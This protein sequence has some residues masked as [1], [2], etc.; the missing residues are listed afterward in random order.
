MAFHPQPLFFL[1]VGLVAGTLVPLS[2]AR[3][4]LALTLALALAGFLCAVAIARPRAVPLNAL[5]IAAAAAGAALSAEAQMGYERRALPREISDVSGAVILEGRLASD[6]RVVDNEM[7][8]EVDATQI[9]ANGVAHAYA[10]R[11]R[12][13]VRSQAERPF[14]RAP[15]LAKGDV[16]RTW[17]ELR[18]P[19]P[20]RTPGGFDQLAWARR[21][22][23]HAFAT[24]KSDR[25]LQVVTRR[26][27]ARGPIDKARDRL[28][29]SWRHVA[30][31]LNRAVTASMVV[32]DEGALDAATRD[33]F[34]SAGLLHLL[35]VSGSQVAALILGLRRAM[36]LSLRISWTGGFIECAV[37]A[38]YCLLAGAENSIVRAT[39]M[40][41][42]FAVA[43]RVD[44]HRGGA[45][46]L[47]ASALALLALPPLDALDPGAQM[48][49]AATLALVTFAGPVSRGL[50]S[51]GLPAVL[52]DILAATLVASLAVIPLSL[53]HFHRFTLIALPANLLAAPLAV[54]LL[55]GSLVTA[56]LDTLFTPLASLA[57]AGC[58]QVAEALRWLARH[59]AAADPDWRGPAPPLAL[60]LGLLGLVASRGWRRVALPAAGLVAA[61]TLS[62]L[63]RGDGRLH[64]WFLDVGQ[65]DAL[66]IEGPS[67]RVSAIDAG[68][69]FERFDAGERVVAEALWELGHRR[70]DFLALTHRHADH[71]GGGP[72]LARHFA[73]A[74]IYVNDESGRM[75]DFKTTAVQRGDSW[76]WDGVTFRVLSPDPSWDLP[77]RD[78][79]ARSLVLEVRHG[80]STFLLMG[81]AGVKTEQRLGLAP[82]R[83]DLVKVGH[84]G[85]PDASSDALVAATRPRLAL[86]SAGSRNRFS[87][88]GPKVV[89]RWARAGAMVWRTDLHRT[90][91][92]TSDGTGIRW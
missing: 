30:D 85:A 5:M 60:V 47:A 23:I 2:G 28:K 78:E 69:A 19:E 68:P 46:F 75:R 59:A 13:F 77:R 11:I 83:F 92:V 62:G 9:V 67:G 70:L 55:Y 24:C 45:N 39:V 32:G 88:P 17:V 33:D 36:P 12:L 1:V 10:G 18:R 61:L 90:L 91:H 41:M 66:L 7:R 22:G 35:V 80:A 86:I 82:R 16:L 49:F 89:G 73:P 8:F 87:H 50:T 43:V 72:F 65:G 48:S 54:A 4:S 56:A 44:L 58:G 20:L 3:A 27:S 76:E 37:L 57:G 6:P 51:R 38:A 26:Q 14:D 63:P 64:L 34:R 21:E 40:A 15:A 84:H 42:A 53:I 52:S 74:R 25:L 81:D 79:N 29:H 31:P 71:E